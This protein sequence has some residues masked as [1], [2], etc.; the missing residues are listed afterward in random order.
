MTYI[1][2]LGGLYIVAGVAGMVRKMKLAG[3][4]RWVIKVNRHSATEISIGCA[5]FF[6]NLFV[7]MG[8]MLH[9]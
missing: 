4:V 2:F 8:A 1:S 5:H 3:H 9:A 6:V 7:V